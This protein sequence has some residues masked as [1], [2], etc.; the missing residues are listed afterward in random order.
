MYQEDPE[1]EGDEVGGDMDDYTLRI[2]GL[3]NAGK[4]HLMLNLIN[5]KGENVIEPTTDYNADMYIYKETK[6]NFW[7]IAGSKE[8]RENWKS[9]FHYS[10]GFIYVVDI[11]D[12]ERL[13]EAK[14]ALHELLMP[15]VNE[16]GIPLLIYANKSDKLSKKVE[17]NDVLNLLG[18]KSNDNLFVQVCSAKTLVGL[19]EGFDWLFSKVKIYN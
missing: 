15:E 13:N 3:D 4:T 17:K 8:N 9:Y 16:G 19:V 1:Y 5:P 2:F 14:T 6:F 7:D 11:S 18:L 12:K 10:D